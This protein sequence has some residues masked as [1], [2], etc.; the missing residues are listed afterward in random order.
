M[1]SVTDW[2]ES[3]RDSVVMGLVD[4]TTPTPTPRQNT[5]VLLVDKA[6]EEHGTH[7]TQSPYLCLHSSQTASPD[8]H[9]TPA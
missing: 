9:R 2:N 5:P 4:P 3:L 8:T 6:K 7:C 1:V